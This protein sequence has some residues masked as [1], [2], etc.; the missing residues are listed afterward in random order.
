[1]LSWI[2]LFS[3][4]SILERKMMGRFHISLCIILSNHH[5]LC[6]WITRHVS[7][8]RIAAQID[9]DAED[10]GSEAIDLSEEQSYLE[11]VDL[12]S[13]SRTSTIPN[14]ID[15]RKK[16]GQPKG[17]T[18]ERRRTGHLCI[19]AGKNKIATKYSEMLLWL[20]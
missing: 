19:I 17:S 5:T 14:P 18:N 12:A 15:H 11:T 6:H 2:I 20:Q 3:L 1:M 4:L 16:G 13:E 7:N 8:K 9:L 10:P